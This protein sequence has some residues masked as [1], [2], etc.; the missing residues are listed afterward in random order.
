MRTAEAKW[1]D[2]MAAIERITDRKM[3]VSFCSSA[4]QTHDIAPTSVHSSSCQT[5]NDSSKLTD[6]GVLS[7]ISAIEAEYAKKVVKLVKVQV[8]FC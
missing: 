7:G 3:N 5:S 4:C 1:Q 2:A 6:D 8:H